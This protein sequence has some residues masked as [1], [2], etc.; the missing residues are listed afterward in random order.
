MAVYRP[1]WPVSSSQLVLWPCSDRNI[2]AVYWV[3]SSIVAVWQKVADQLQT[4]G[5][6]AATK[7]PKSG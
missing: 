2:V 1:N 3:D 4:S 5:R 6:L 7:S